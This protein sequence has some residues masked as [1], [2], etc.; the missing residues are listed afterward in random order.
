M[1]VDTLDD[2]AL[3]RSLDGGFTSRV[4]DLG[5]VR[6][7]YVAGGPEDAP[8]LFLLGGWPQTWWQ[9]RKVM[10]ALARR[11]RVV[12]VDLRGMGG[13][14]R[15][16][17]GYDKRTMAGDV[18]A[19]ADHLGMD[20]VSVTGHDIGAMVAYAHAALFPE[21]T[22]RISLLDVPHPDEGWASFTLLPGPHQ[23][24]GAGTVSAAYLWWFAFNQVQGLPEALLEGRSRL[25]A[26]W[27]FDR[28]SKDPA[29]IDEH[30]RRVYARAYSGA[31]AIRSGNAWYRAFPTDI[32]HERDYGRVEAP[33]LA[34]GGDESSYAYLREL[35]PSKGAD[36]RVVEIAD[37]GHYLPEEQPEAVVA[38]LEEFL[39]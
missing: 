29:S 30:A 21:A 1:T 11:R 28:S 35:M 31:D 18:R 17:G 3:A 26:D 8:P 6:L 9:W 32:A 24:D 22:D 15:P 25:L 27:L 36:V 4:A 37:C 34:L 39:R 14:S 13:S 38:A 2:A 19:L 33:L 12:A 10:P 7:H 16:E 5:E 20:R 23:Y